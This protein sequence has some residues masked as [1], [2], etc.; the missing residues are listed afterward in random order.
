M[1]DDKISEDTNRNVSTRELAGRMSVIWQIVRPLEAEIGQLKRA[2]AA[3]AP[4][5]LEME[6][7]LSHLEAPIWSRFWRWCVRIRRGLTWREYVN[8]IVALACED[9][10]AR[11][12]DLNPPASDEPME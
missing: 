1:S 12:P 10:S 11:R 2:A 4:A 6:V 3:Y 8:R 5:I 9:L 7:R